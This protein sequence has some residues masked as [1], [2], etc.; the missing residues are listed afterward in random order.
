MSFKIDSRDDDLNIFSNHGN[1]YQS[2]KCLANVIYINTLSC[3]FNRNKN[4][5]IFYKWILSSSR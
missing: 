1:G 4:S 5:C 2:A 3:A